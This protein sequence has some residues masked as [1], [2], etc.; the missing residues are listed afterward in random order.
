M[1]GDSVPKKEEE[2]QDAWVLMGR[3]GTAAF[4]VRAVGCW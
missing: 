3:G 1:V 2:E 4:D